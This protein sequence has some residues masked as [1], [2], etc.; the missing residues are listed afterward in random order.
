MHWLNIIL[1]NNNLNY[2]N[3]TI[4]IVKIQT[5]IKMQNLEIKNHLFQNNKKVHLN[6]YRVK[7][8]NILK[9]IHQDIIKKEQHNI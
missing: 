2:F 9:I 1:L 7:R 4:N 3:K 6:N 8:I 5:L